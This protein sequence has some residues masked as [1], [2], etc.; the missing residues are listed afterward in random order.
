MKILVYDTRRVYNKRKHMKKI[1]LILSLFF[2]LLSIPAGRVS[3]QDDSGGILINRGIESLSIEIIPEPDSSAQCKFIFTNINNF[4]T[5]FSWDFFSGDIN[6]QEINIGGEE[7]PLNQV[8]VEKGEFSKV[9]F[10]ILA[11]KLDKLEID[12]QI[13]GAISPVKEAAQFYLIVLNNSGF[14]LNNLDVKLTDGGFSKILDSRY[15]AVHGVARSSE[16][17][18]GR[19]VEF[20]GKD[21][22][23]ESIF[24]IQAD[25]P[26]K[27]FAFSFTENFR[28]FFENLGSGATLGLAFLFPALALLILFFV[29]LRNRL[30]N[31]GKVQGY[32]TMPPDN[33]SPAI[34]GLLLH[35]SVTSREISATIFDLLRRDYLV[36]V[37]KENGIVFG[38]KK[39]GDDLRPYEQRLMRE[40]FKERAIKSNLAEIESKEEEEV[41]DPEIEALY[42]E[43]YAEGSALSLFEKNPLRTQIIYNILGIFLF[44]F[45]FLMILIVIF[46]FPKE[47]LLIF[48]PIGLGVAS[49]LIM[50]LGRVATPRTS[51][52]TMELKKWLEFKNYL[53]GGFALSNPGEKI[54]EDYL[55]FAYV[56]GAD[57]HWM[58]I[59]S[60]LIQTTPSFYVTVKPYVP[61]E[62]WYAKT[63]GVIESTAKEIEH[64]KGLN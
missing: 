20:L 15:F 40:L 56:L 57:R 32:R 58:A 63:I 60:R 1:V 61:M 48:S 14:S 42:R 2:C 16:Q 31:E 36:L 19:G 7:L 6:L 17:T 4:E 10:P 62:E 5:T 26:K 39:E 54:F 24:S 34:L 28:S 43:I 11:G 30:R 27:D 55:P 25:F 9:S 41:V 47:P 18:I 29:S 59:F 13:K 21:L 46:F 44:L 38:K 49:F 64:L 35:L 12:L 45:S 3:A 23:H 51:M 8:T 37:E 53:S 52:G 33:L 22:S 50:R